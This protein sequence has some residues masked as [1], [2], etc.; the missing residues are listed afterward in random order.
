MTI[1][2]GQSA[3]IS[4]PAHKEF[5]EMF[6]PIVARQKEKEAKK[7][8]ARLSHLSISLRG[9]QSISPYSAEPAFVTA[10]PMKPQ[11]VKA[12][13]IMISCIY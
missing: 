1:T 4:F 5:A 12:N 8:A 10:I 9:S 2:F 7:A 6:V 3:V 11:K 13:G